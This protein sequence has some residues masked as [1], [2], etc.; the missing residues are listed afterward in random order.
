[1]NDAERQAAL[2]AADL[3]QS[4]LDALD[5]GELTAS[6]AQGA[7]LRR[8]IEGAIVG[9]RLSRDQGTEEPE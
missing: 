7:R 9:L 5:Q 6:G 4:L 3:L 8:R 2:E 1:M